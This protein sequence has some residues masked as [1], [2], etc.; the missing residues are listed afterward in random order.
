VVVVSGA[1]VVVGSEWDPK[2][3]NHAFS[4]GEG[5]VCGITDCRMSVVR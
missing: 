3:V 5:I 1:V 4:V 2:L